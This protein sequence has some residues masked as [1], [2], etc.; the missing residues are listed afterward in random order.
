MKDVPEC[1]MDV[2]EGF[3]GPEDDYEFK[4]EKNRPKDIKANEW[5]YRMAYEAN[6]DKVKDYE[7]HQNEEEYELDK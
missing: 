6:G 4:W 5:S 3:S 7:L 2:M 1:T